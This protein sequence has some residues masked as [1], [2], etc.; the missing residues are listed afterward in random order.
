MVGWKM[1]L[2]SHTSSAALGCMSQQTLWHV[3]EPEVAPLECKLPCRMSSFSLEP[4]KV[5]SN[6]K[7]SYVCVNDWM[8]ESCGV[9][10][11]V[12]LGTLSIYR[13][14]NVRGELSWWRGGAKRDLW[15]LVWIPVQHLWPWTA[16][17]KFFFFFFRNPKGFSLISRL[18]NFKFI[19]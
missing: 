18:I 9:G 15:S 13:V 3:L 16:W 17:H 14:T 2:H 19:F 11:V 7:T 12:R 6:L 1:W 10:S 5:C 4:K 8:G